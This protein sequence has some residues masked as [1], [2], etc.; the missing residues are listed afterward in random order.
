MFLS[1]LVHRSSSVCVAGLRVVLFFALQS[2]QLAA[3]HTVYIPPVFVRGD[4]FNQWLEPEDRVGVSARCRHEQTLDPRALGRF[5]GPDGKADFTIGPRYKYDLYSSLLIHQGSGANDTERQSVILSPSS[6]LQK[7]DV[8]L[9]GNVTPGQWRQQKQLTVFANF[10]F[11]SVEQRLNAL[12]Q[13]I[14]DKRAALNNDYQGFFEGRYNNNAAPLRQTNLLNAKFNNAIQRDAGLSALT[15]GMAFQNEFERSLLLR[16]QVLSSIPCGEKSDA[17]Y[18]FKPRRGMGRH[19][20]V[21]IGIDLEIP[22]FEGLRATVGVSDMFWL[23]A[24]DVRTAGVKFRPFSYYLGLGKQGQQNE[25]VTPAANILTQDCLVHL[26]NATM[27]K[28]G[29]EGLFAQG[30]R[31]FV[32]WNGM[33]KEAEK[34]NFRTALP[35]ATYAIAAGTYNTTQPF[36]PT[37]GDNYEY[38]DFID[39]A[40]GDLGDAAWLQS[41]DLDFTVSAMPSCFEHAFEFGWESLQ[42]IKLGQMVGGPRIVLGYR[43]MQG[44]NAH[45]L[46]NVFTCEIGIGLNF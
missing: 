39:P 20:G 4:F 18:L 36:A 13:P 44:E 7:L 29:L 14:I 3:E 1:K 35:N 33:Y 37:L 32:A 21:G 19:W 42:A 34:V 2:G 41:K 45:I 12:W 28:F 46:P 40:L 23:P 24:Y 31:V 30:H 38:F 17:S 26:G 11:A 5:L 16:A 25:P 6:S 8:T 27:M 22:L 15:F 43:A 10:D 9:W